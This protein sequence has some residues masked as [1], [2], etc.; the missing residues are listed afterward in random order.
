MVSESPSALDSR[1][2]RAVLQQQQGGEASWLCSSPSSN[3][4]DANKLT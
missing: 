4:S 1:L 2:A 3:L